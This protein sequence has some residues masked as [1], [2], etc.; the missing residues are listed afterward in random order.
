MK[1]RKVV[2]PATVVV[3]I[4]SLFVVI[5]MTPVPISLLIRKLFENPELAPPQGYADMDSR[6]TV[7]QDITYE[8]KYKSNA[9]DIY[10]PKD[11]DEL[12]PVVLWIHGGGYVGGDKR[13]VRYYAVSLASEGY[14][15]ISMNYE[16]APEARYPTP[17]M[18]IEEVFSWIS[19][20]SAEYLL[21]SSRIV[22]AGD[23]AGAHSAATFAAIQT[24]PDYENEIGIK[25]SV[26]DGCIKGLLLYCA[27]Y[28][29]VMVNEIGGAFGFLLN[30]AGWAYFGTRDWT[31]TFAKLATVGNHVTR[32]FP[33][34][35]IT[36]GNTA[37]FEKQ[38]IAFADM[39][40]FAGVENMR[41]FIPHEPEKIITGH[42]YQFLMDTDAGAECYRLTLAFL[43]EHM[44]R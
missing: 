4:I 42:E 32:D 15:V 21:D 31:D 11:V 17:V 44:N 26:K 36:D 29:V 30:R 24:N 9:L 38:G 25:A 33:P 19:E 12:V 10:L 7:H 34:T 13:D 27:P 40:D 1:I 28:D 16:R 35:F 18:Q 2:I 22:L 5:F 41:Y 23:S 39:L 6:V 3:I 20:C 43:K 37:S 14:A 8:S